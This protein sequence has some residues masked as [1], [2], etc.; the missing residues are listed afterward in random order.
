MSDPAPR[1][2]AALADRYRIRQSGA[3]SRRSER[4]EPLLSVRVLFRHYNM[5]IIAR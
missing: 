5:A 1:L 4:A 3:R 2:T